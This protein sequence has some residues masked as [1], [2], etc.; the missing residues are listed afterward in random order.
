MKG[1][2]MKIKGS[3]INEMNLKNE[4]PWILG[5]GSPSFLVANPFDKPFKNEDF[6]QILHS[7]FGWPV[8]SC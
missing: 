2:E 8:F 1:H 4:K 6:F 7:W 5:F 3:E